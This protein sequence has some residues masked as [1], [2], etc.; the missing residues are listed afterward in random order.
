MFDE[1]TRKKREVQFMNIL[2][3]GAKGHGGNRPSAI[4]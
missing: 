1:H 4:T 2:V 3:T